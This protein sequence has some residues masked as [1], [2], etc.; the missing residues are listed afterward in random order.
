MAER[1]DILQLQRPHRHAHLG[2]DI[3]NANFFARPVTNQGLRDI[4]SIAGRMPLADGRLANQQLRRRDGDRLARDPFPFDHAMQNPRRLVADLFGG[5][6]NRRD[7]RRRNSHQFAFDQ[8]DDGHVL[9]NP[10]TQPTGDAA[11]RPG[12]QTETG[13]HPERLLRCLDEIHQGWVGLLDPREVFV[14][15]VARGICDFDDFVHR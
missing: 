2:G 9:G 13:D 11:H 1:R 7:R 12:E 4:D 14:L 8:A 10:Q 3:L 15:A 6:A 5:A